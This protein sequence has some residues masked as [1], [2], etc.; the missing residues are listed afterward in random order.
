MIIAAAPLLAASITRDPLAIASIT[1]AGFAPWLLLG[2]PAGALVDR[3]NRKTVMISA[4]LARATILAGVVALLTTDFLTVPVLVAAIFLIGVASCF[5]EPASHAILPALVGRSPEQLTKLNGRLWSADTF[6]RSLAGPPIGSVSYTTGPA[7]P[8]GLDLATFL[9]SAAL[10]TR[11]KPAPVTAA[12]RA[13][14]RATIAEGLT[15]LLRHPV[16]RS[17][18]LGMTGYNLGYN[19]AAATLILYAQDILHINTA[20]YGL[21]LGTG[22]LGATAAGPLVPRIIRN[23]TPRQVYA[24]AFALQAACWALVVITPNAWI[25]AA[26]LAA[27]GIGSAVVTINSASIRQHLTPDTMLGRITAAT[28]LLGIGSA[29]L[30]ALIGGAIA[31]LTTLTTAIMTAVALLAACALAFIVSREPR[32]DPRPDQDAR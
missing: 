9:I 23:R 2:L 26:T 11:V 22:A 13:T 3:W 8:F 24:A 4:D 31:T 5:F 12:P 14:M 19:L 32:T 17:L 16:L 25:T 21:L 7:L 20:S 1:A 28:R 10:L 6:G 15:Y 29:A 27:L 30:G 18:A